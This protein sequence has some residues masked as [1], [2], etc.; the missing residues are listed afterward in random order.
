MPSISTFSPCSFGFSSTLTQAYIIC[1][2]FQKWYQQ[3][4]I[5]PRI[6][7]QN[8][9]LLSWITILSTST[10]FNPNVLTNK[11]LL[12]F[13]SEL[14]S[15]QRALMSILSKTVKETYFSIMIL[16]VSSAESVFFQPSSLM[17]GLGWLW[18]CV[19]SLCSSGAAWK[20]LSIV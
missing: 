15:N 19:P 2:Q 3:L 4:D 14:I 8:I 12:L 5:D 18:L 7:S 11:C 16:T 13:S 10:I 20:R 17:S 1:M 9:Y 6:K